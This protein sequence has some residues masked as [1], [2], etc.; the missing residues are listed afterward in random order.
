M[1][2]T[3]IGQIPAVWFEPQNVNRRKL[4]IFLTGFSGDK[5][6]VRPQLEALAARGFVALS[7]DPYQHGERTTESRADL[8]TRV[9][10]NIRRFFWPIL[11]Q[12]AEEVPMIIDWAVQH[13]GVEPNVAM[14]GTSMG[15]DISVA[16]AGVDARIRAVSAIVG[17]PDWMRP[18]SFE[19]PG[20]PDE[21]A[22]A[23]YNRRNPMTHLEAY[24]TCPAIT[25]ES[26]ANDRQVPP[27]S[28]QQFIEKLKPY[29]ASCPER[30]RVTLHPNVAHGYIPAMLENSIQ[31]FERW[32]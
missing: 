27:E 11:A 4:A 31:W 25:F 28:G 1:N 6:S 30:L 23:A 5:N 9:R 24:R 20:T 18:G 17:T 26:G 22:Q 14:G 10:G 3:H 19:Y 15:G 7:F 21:V 16:A 8:A 2:H 13:L 32:L 12:T 29:Y